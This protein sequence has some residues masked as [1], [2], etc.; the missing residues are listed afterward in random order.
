MQPPKPQQ[1]TNLATRIG[2]ALTTSHNAYSPLYRHCYEGSG[3]VEALAAQQNKK[4]LVLARYAQHLEQILALLE[5]DLSDMGEQWTEPAK[6]RI[7]NHCHER[8]ALPY[9]EL[10]TFCRDWARS[11]LGEL[12]PSEIL[13][14]QYAK[15]QKYGRKKEI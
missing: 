5:T 12:P 13:D 7:C 15:S 8:L 3:N 11:H 1:I 2:H 9:A 6:K 10:C 4:R 14:Q